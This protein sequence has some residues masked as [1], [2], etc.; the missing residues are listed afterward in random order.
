[1]SY[2]EVLLLNHLAGQPSHGHDHRRRVESTTGFELHNNSLYPALRRFEEAGAVTRSVRSQ[3]RRPPRQV[4]PITDAGRELLDD[5]RADL[6]PAQAG[7]A[8]FLSQLGQFELLRPAERCAVLDARLTAADARI[9]HT[10][11]RLAAEATFPP[12]G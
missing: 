9:R 8:E 10:R 2:V 4:H 1:M 5:M 7:D 6:T 11:R 3:E 12:G